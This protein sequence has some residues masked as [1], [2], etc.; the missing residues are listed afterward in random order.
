MPKTTRQSTRR[1]SFHV[2]RS[3]AARIA[4][5]V[6]RAVALYETV[7]IPRDTLDITM[8]LRACRA[9]GCRLDLAKLLAFRDF[10]FM[11]DV[12]GIAEHLDHDTG[13]LT[14]CFLPRCAAPDPPRRR[15][16]RRAHR[17][18][19]DIRRCPLGTTTTCAGCHGDLRPQDAGTTTADGLVWCDDCAHHRMDGGG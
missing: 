3:D 12:M 9:N 7:G 6:K 2:S 16:A 13:Q 15:R 11:H 8:D 18:A 1:L 19:G 10:D 17:Q 4:I 14:D 5:A